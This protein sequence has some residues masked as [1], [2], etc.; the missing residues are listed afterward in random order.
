MYNV[1]LAF[2]HEFNLLEL[3]PFQ[4]HEKIANWD[5]NAKFHVCTICFAYI[6]LHETNSCLEK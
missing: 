3:S 6:H 2:S 4:K 5:T 1:P